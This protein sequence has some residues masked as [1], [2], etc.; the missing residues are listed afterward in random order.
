MSFS[1]MFTTFHVKV[2]GTLIQTLAFFGIGFMAF[3]LSFFVILH[4]V[5]F[6]DMLNILN[7]CGKAGPSC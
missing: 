7:L 1:W 6:F 5:K 3:G 4:K 2:L